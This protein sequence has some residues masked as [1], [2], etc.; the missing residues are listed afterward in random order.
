MAAT[1]VRVTGL[2]DLR[3][4]LRKISRD[5]DREVRESLREAARPVLD[6]AQRLFRPFSSSSADG[7]K[8]R[9]RQRGVAVE[10]SKR[11]TTGLHPEWGRLQMGVAFIPALQN[12]A[13]EV[14][15]R[16]DAGVVDLAKRNGW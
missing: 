7:Y 6:E 15:E 16:V 12:K 11:R 5:A 8:I 10:Q 1:T 14:V 2:Q 13:D 9:V 4:D 3:K